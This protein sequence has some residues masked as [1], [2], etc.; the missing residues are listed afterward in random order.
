MYRKEVRR[1]RAILVALIVASLVLISIH[2]SEGDDGPLHSVQ[3][4]VANALAPI[5]EGASRALKPVRDLVNWFDETFDARGELDALREENAELRSQLAEAQSALGQ[6]EQFRE[7][8]QLDRS[9]LLAG[10]EPVTARVIGRSPTVWYGTVRIDKGSS[11]GIE[12]NDPVVAG[13]EDPREYGGALVGRVSEVT[14]GSAVVQL[15]TDHRSAV[16]ARI[17][18]DG[19]EGVVEPEAGDPDDLLLD[20]IQGDEGVAEGAMIVTAGWSSGRISSAYP[21]GIPVG[22]VTEAT[23]SEQEAFQRV[24]LRPFADLRDLQYVQVMTGGRRPGVPG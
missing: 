18:P 20:L 12:E 8:L 15:I 6:N 21:P 22:R 7:L 5:E 1:R 13:V 4:A 24:H 19:P 9:G 3:R 17:N 2:F 10:Y 11:A 23:L 14:A 16:S